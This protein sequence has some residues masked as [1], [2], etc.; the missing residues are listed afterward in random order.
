MTY[1]N[2]TFNPNRLTDFDIIAGS[3]HLILKT[4]RQE[5]ESSIWRSQ[6]D[7]HSILR[8]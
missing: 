1:C 8:K 7:C 2:L 4:Y 3:N 5:L 6:L